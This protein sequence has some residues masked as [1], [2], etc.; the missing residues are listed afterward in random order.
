MKTT[1]KKYIKYVL[2][3]KN[4]ILF[5]YIDAICLNIRE[6]KIKGCLLLDI[7]NTCMHVIRN[8]NKLF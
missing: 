6:E 3:V 4:L 5:I 2:V 1:Q 8:Y 7:N